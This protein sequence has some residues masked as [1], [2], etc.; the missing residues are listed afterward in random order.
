LLFRTDVRRRCLDA[1]EDNKTR[2]TVLAS[3]IRDK[4][5]WNER[6]SKV[7]GYWIKDLSSKLISFRGVSPPHVS[8]SGFEAQPISYKMCEDAYFLEEEAPDS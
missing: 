4:V 7:T 2:N 1:F 3:R 6:F 8:N 5:L